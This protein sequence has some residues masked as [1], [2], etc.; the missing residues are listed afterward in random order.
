MENKLIYTHGSKK[1][2]VFHADELTAIAMLIILKPAHY[3]IKRV[4]HQTK[5]FPNADY[6]IDIGREYEPKEGKFDH[7]QWEGGLSSAGLIAKHLDV[8]PE[9]HPSLAR[10]VNKVDRNDV[11]IEMA[12]EFEYSRIIS[13]FNQNSTDEDL[14]TRVFYAALD[15]AKIT[16]N[17]LIKKDLESIETTKLIKELL[18]KQHP[19]ATTLEFPHYLAGWQSQI[20]G[21]L[22][23]NIQ[24]VIWP[25]DAEE[26]N[27]Q[28]A[29]LKAKEYGLYGKK[30]PLHD[31]M[32]FVHANG[33]FGVSLTKDTLLEYIDNI[34]F[35]E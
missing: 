7:H 1:N 26:W 18:G 3:T 8:T 5:E 19:T 15:L 4:G 13:L 32:E 2:W 24:H 12:T 9:T 31:S 25:T 27:I 28:V 16:V 6:I 11:G 30:L 14:Q 23:P 29:P 21:E 22:T 34:V 10:L 17:A 20:N 35:G 33:F